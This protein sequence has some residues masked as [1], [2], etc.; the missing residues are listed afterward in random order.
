[1][2]FGTCSNHRRVAYLSLNFAASAKGEFAKHGGISNITLKAA[3]HDDLFQS[4]FKSCLYG[5]QSSQ[6]VRQLA[7]LQARCTRPLR[8]FTIRRDFEAGSQCLNPHP[9]QGI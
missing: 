3:E 4:Y 8:A 9:F 2:I 5:E 6:N 7:A 1:M